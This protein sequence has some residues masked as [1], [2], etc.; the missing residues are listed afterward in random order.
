MSDISSDD[1]IPTMPSD[2]S[3]MFSGLLGGLSG[4]EQVE[5]PEVMNRATSG[6]AAYELYSAVDAEIPPGCTV[7]IETGIPMKLPPG[8][9]LNIRTKSRHASGKSI[10]DQWKFPERKDENGNLYTYHSIITLAGVIDSDF[11]G[12]IKVLLHNLSRNHSFKVH[13]GDSVAQ[14]ILCRV[15]TFANEHVI[16]PQNNDHSGFGST[17]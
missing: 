1:E 4:L 17:N 15:H 12:T 13:K 10:R 3:G 5:S 7:M 2:L 8:W 9:W 11:S 16:N 6:S 14:G